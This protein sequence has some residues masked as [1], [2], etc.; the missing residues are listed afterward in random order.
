MATDSRREIGERVKILLLGTWIK[1]FIYR[2][3]SITNGQPKS[4]LERFRGTKHGQAAQRAIIFTTKGNLNK[5]WLS[6]AHFFVRQFILIK[7]EVRHQEY[8]GEACGIEKS[9]FGLSRSATEHFVLLLER[10]DGLV[11]PC[12]VFNGDFMQLL[13][14][15]QSSP[16]ET[17]KN[18]MFILT[19]VFLYERSKWPLIKMAW[20]AAPRKLRTRHD[21]PRRAITF[22]AAESNAFFWNLTP[23]S[24]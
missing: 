18:S 3:G 15:V 4:R 20:R 8:C 5:S 2:I 10:I 16:K 14:N 17:F 21:N 11:Q 19:R 7:T 23:Q 12:V 1:K 9:V 22:L 6:K 24:K 13:V